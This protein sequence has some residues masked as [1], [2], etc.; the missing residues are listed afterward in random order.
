VPFCPNRTE[1]DLLHKRSTPAPKA[2]RSAVTAVVALTLLGPLL[3]LASS[4]PAAAAPIPCDPEALRAAIDVANDTAGPDTIELAAGCTYS[5]SAVPA[6]RRFYWYGPSALPA[7]ASDITIIGN[8][9]TIERSA[10]AP[11]PFRLIFVAP[12]PADPKTLDY[13]G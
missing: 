13:H 2:G 9:A 7:I 8:G 3:V 4:G 12:D 1:A 11:L 10:A 5:Y 6:D